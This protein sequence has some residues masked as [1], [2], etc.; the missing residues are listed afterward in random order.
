MCLIG[1]ATMSNHVSSAN[2]GPAVD[3][4]HSS[5]EANGAKNNDKIPAEKWKE[6]HGDLERSGSSLQEGSSVQDPSVT[7]LWVLQGWQHRDNNQRQPETRTSMPQTAL[8]S[9]NP[10]TSE[11]VSL[12]HP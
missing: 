10:E 12:S 3:G 9:V 8:L 5:C 1:D 2:V 4:L 6:T 7:L 11:Q